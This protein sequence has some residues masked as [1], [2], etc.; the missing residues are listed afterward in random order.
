MEGLRYSSLD[1][2]ESIER[3][4]AH[5]VALEARNAVAPAQRKAGRG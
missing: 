2:R 4:L 1:Y 5:D 3:G